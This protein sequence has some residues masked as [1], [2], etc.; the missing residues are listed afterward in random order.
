MANALIVKNVRFLVTCDDSNRILEHGDMLVRDGV[1][2]QMGTGL[3]APADAQVLDA[4]GMILYPGLIN[5][6]H[7][8]Y[9]TFSRNLPQVQR[10]ELFPWLKTLYEIWK[11]LDDES[12]YYSTITGAGELLKHGCTTCLDHHYVFPQGRSAGFL[13]AQF[14]AADALG[15]RFHATRGSMDLSVK[16]GGLPPDSVVQPLDEILRDSQLAVEKFHDPSR[17]AM[18]Q[19]ALAPCSPFSVSEALLRESAALARSL[20]VRLHTHLAET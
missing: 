17:Y 20:G 5:T 10:M 12:V 4:T 1:I 7:H 18:H 3:Q 2:A 9:Q 19:V 15:I 8:L 6:H 13:D 16:D 11:N 14:A